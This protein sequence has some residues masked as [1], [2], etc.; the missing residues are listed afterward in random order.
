MVKEG[1][2]KLV[3]SSVLD[4][5]E[6]EYAE[7]YWVKKAQASLYGRVAK[8]ELKTTKVS[9]ELVTVSILTSCQTT[10]DMPLCRLPY[11][12]WL[13]MLLICDAH[14]SGHPDIA[15]T[16][17][18]T[19]RRYWIINGNKIS[20]TVK[21]QCT[22]CKE[23]GARVETRFMA[24]LPRNRL[25][26]VTPP[27]V[28]TACDYFG[29]FKVGIHRNTTAKHYGV[30]FTCLNTKAVHCELA[31]DASKMEFL[32]VLDDSFLPRLPESSVF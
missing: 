26:P 8:G 10:K 11:D 21:H 29:P 16:T 31:A 19:R 32:Q 4:P 18:K 30:L 22:F 7:E 5:E 2:T 15:P 12:H 6:N 24:N 1:R 3:S 13:S 9:F 28:Y 20:K 27:F 23:M 25:Q 17:A 14:Q